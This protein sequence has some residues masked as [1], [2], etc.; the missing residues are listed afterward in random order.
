M[1]FQQQLYAGFYAQKLGGIDLLDN[2]SEMT[3][4]S[5]PMGGDL[6]ITM[7]PDREPVPQNENVIYTGTITNNGPDTASQVTFNTTIPANE[8]LVDFSCDGSCSS[9]SSGQLLPANLG[10]MPAGTTRHIYL[11]AQVQAQGLAAGKA[12]V[13][14]PTQDDNLLNNHFYFGSTGGPPA[15]TATATAT[16]APTATA[17]ATVAPSATATATPKP[18]PT[19]TPKP[20][21]TAT[22]TATAKPTV[23]PMTTPKATAT[24]TA[25]PSQLLNISTRMVVQTGDNVLI[26]GFIITGSDDKKVI[27]RGIGPSLPLP[28]ALQDP[29]LELHD[30]TGALIAMNNNWRD[31]PAAAAEISATGVAP[32]NPLESAIV[33]T[34]PGNGSAYTAIV[35]GLGDSTGIAL[36]EGYD[37]SQPAASKLANIST[38]GF[39][40]TGDNVMIGGFII[41][42]GNGVGK[43]LIRAIGPSLTA[44]GVANALQDP[45]LEL[46]NSS[47]TMI[48]S[49]DDWRTHQEAEITASGAPPTDD[50][51]S[52]IIVTLQGGGYTA[53]VKGKSGATG[54]GLVEVYSLH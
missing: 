20:T 47:G 13:S 6:S 15:P 12:S 3:G 50:R 10:D 28:G 22:P 36:V 7:Q 18:T 33:R 27:L 17:T 38:R 40:N 31:D 30:S 1:K 5:P 43:V 39:I 21:A 53:I 11:T 14:S 34:L 42:N 48:A 35:R 8:S 49:D 51:E 29:V 26:A 19:V 25:S 9:Q 52:A 23:S 4:A 45:T 24:P 2:F 46:F 16:V 41:G 37:L 54:V 44:A 32:Q